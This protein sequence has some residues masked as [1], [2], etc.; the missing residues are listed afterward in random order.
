MN[1]WDEEDWKRFEDALR[2]RE[3]WELATELELP[4]PDPTPLRALAARLDE[5]RTAAQQLLAP[6][7]TSQESFE[8]AGVGR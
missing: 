2:D 1:E 6:L 8:G 7:L 3:P 5:E 4:P